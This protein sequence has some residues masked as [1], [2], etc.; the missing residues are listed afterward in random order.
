MRLRRA[1][2]AASGE[3]SR[4]ATRSALENP[5]PMLVLVTCTLIVVRMPPPQCVTGFER[6]TRRSCDTNAAYRRRKPAETLNNPS[7]SKTFPRRWV[8]RPR[9]RS[10]SRSTPHRD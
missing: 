5:L 9:S 1:H 4:D 6:P 3:A 2:N 8:C 10:E 7:V